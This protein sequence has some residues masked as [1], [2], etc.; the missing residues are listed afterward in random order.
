MGMGWHRQ[1]G[2]LREEDQRRGRMMHDG[3]G[4]GRMESRAPTAALEH[5]GA[6]GLTGEEKGRL[7]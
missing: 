7:G 1:G 6:L 3:F 2:S 4:E 5:R